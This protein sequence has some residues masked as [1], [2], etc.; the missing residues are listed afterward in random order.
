MEGWSEGGRKRGRELGRAVHIC[1][2][3]AIFL[4]CVIPFLLL[5]ALRRVC[6]IVSGPPARQVGNQRAIRQFLTTPLL[7]IGLKRTMS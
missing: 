7:L 5:F 1:E 4:N 6:D 2:N 3:G